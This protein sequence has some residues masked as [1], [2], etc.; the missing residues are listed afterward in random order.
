[1]CEELPRWFFV[2]MTFLAKVVKLRD[3]MKFISAQFSTRVGEVTINE[4]MAKLVKMRR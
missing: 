3:K 2:W 1:M 4:V